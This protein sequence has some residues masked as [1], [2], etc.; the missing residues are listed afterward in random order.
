M[1]SSKLN[2]IYKEYYNYCKINDFDNNFK[3]ISS[4]EGIVQNSSYKQLIRDS[5]KQNRKYNGYFYTT[6]KRLEKYVV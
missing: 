2:Q 1:F 5:E 6:L 4:R 3:I